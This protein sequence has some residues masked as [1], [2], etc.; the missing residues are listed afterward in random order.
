MLTH[1]PKGS[2]NSPEISVKNSAFR[3]ANVGIGPYA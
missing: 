2:L 1:R 3:R